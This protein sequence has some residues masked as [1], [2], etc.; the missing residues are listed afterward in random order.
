[1]LQNGETHAEP[2]PIGAGM[3]EK[4]VSLVTVAEAARRTG[5]SVS[6][7]RRMIDRGVLQRV[8]P[9]PGMNPRIPLGAL[10]ALLAREARRDTSVESG[11]A[12][13]RSREGRAQR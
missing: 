5:Y 3:E 1:M 2:T 9:A 7:I 11:L 13:G 6:T 4:A 8:Q 10:H 12:W